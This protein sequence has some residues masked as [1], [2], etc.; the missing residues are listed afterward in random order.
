VTTIPFTPSLVPGQAPF[1]FQATLDGRL[2]T[3]IVTW[4]LYGQRWYVAIIDQNG[5]L[6]T[7]IPMVGSSNGRELANQSWSVGTGNGGVVTATTLSPHGY[8]L[9]MVVVLSITGTLP[10]AYNV[11]TPAWITGRSEFIYPLASDPGAM[12]VPGQYSYDINLVSGY[13]RSSLVWR[14]QNGNLEVQ[15]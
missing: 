12:V 2:Y 6:I 1:T 15:P 4:S 7:R 14:I 13:F 10:N 11:V 5:N 3:C 9:G 8:R